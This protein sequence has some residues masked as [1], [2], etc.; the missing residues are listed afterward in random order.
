MNHIYH[1]VLFVSILGYGPSS[2]AM[3]PK[4]SN[5]ESA[6]AQWRPQG[7]NRNGVGRKLC[8]LWVGRFRIDCSP[9]EH[10][11]EM[12]LCTAVIGKP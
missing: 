2:M 12:C 3:V 1:Q 10:D 11:C 9:E 4:S 5:L 6:H 8:T 7:K